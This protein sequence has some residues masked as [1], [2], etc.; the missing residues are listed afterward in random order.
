MAAAAATWWRCEVQRG[1]GLNENGRVH[2]LRHTFGAQLATIGVPPKAIQ[3]LMGHSDL[4]TT[5]R[6]MHLTPQ[7][8]TDAIRRLDAATGD[9][10]GTKKAP[11]PNMQ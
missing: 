11:A 7:A 4:T 6:Y 9:M 2:I 10:L 5:L 3:E 1:A 8:T